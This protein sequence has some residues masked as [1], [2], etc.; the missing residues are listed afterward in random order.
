MSLTSRQIAALRG[1]GT[2][3]LHTR[4]TPTVDFDLDLSRADERQLTE[5]RTALLARL[6]N[7]EPGDDL[8]QLS[9]RANAVATAIREHN[10]RV[11]AAE[12]ARAALVGGTVAHSSAG[13]DVASGD[14]E[15]RRNDEPVTLGR[16]FVQSEAFRS[17]GGSGK[18]GTVVVPGHVRALFSTAN[19][20]AAPTRL[21]GIQG[22]PQSPTTI[23]DLVDRQTMTTNVVEWVREDAS[24]DAA[25]EVAE[26]Q[27]KPESSYTL[28]LVTDVAATIAHYVNITRQA[29]ADDA[30]IEGYLNGKLT[31][32][33]LKRLNA[34]IL[35]GD[36]TSPN[37]R[38]ILNQPGLGAYV[39]AAGEQ[40]LIAARK[41]RTVAELS[42]YAPDAIV[43]HPIDWETAELDTDSTGRFRVAANV[44]EGAAPRLWGLTVVVSTNMAQ[45]RFLVGGFREG[46]TLWEREGVEVYITDSHASNF[47]SNILTMLAEM[48]A[49]LSVWRP[50]AFVAG[51]LTPAV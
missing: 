14:G 5:Q 13:A 49:A 40:L 47:T 4:A 32:G 51:T 23:L 7:P 29:L 27:V 11:Q 50:K 42:E 1:V 12:A 36:G 18:S 28:S 19:S 41:A 10:D 20:L 2:L 30:Q 45:G 31:R 38:G 24:N 39:S 15:Q 25:A 34:Q 48:R 3:E 46:A 21:P 9:E 33:L 37:L 22:E 16:A 26:G 35:N 43:V 17:Y 6:Q 8:T 44:S